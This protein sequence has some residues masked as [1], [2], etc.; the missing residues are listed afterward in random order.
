MHNGF[1]GDLLELLAFY[2]R[3]F[4]IGLTEQEKLDLQAFLKAL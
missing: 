2:D 3:R 1:T 4:T